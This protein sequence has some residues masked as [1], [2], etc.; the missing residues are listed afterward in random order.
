MDIYL[1]A[2]K[3][4]AV[5]QARA[6][7]GVLSSL[8]LKRGAVV[9]MSVV[10]LGSTSASQLKLGIKIKNDYEGVL[11]ALATADSAQ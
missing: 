10:I 1:N 7:G 2:Q 8:R 3:S 5:W 6:D 9:P 4:P 11:M